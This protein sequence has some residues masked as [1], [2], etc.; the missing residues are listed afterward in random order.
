MRARHNH[1]HTVDTA[2]GIGVHDMQHTMA[3]LSDNRQTKGW[4]TVAESGN[5][6]YGSGN[7][8][9]DGLATDK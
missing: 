2:M 4:L 1:C 5:R 8:Q 7:K 6:H 9:V 3:S